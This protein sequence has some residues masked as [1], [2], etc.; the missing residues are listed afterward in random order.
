MRPPFQGLEICWGIYPGRCPGLSNDAPLG[1]GNDGFIAR[2]SRLPPPPQRA[3]R[4]M[5]DVERKVSFTKVKAGHLIGQSL[6]GEAH[7]AMP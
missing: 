6:I 5:A 7:R 2:P 3:Q 1:L 4:G